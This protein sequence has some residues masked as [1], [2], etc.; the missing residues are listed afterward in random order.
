MIKRAKVVRTI[1]WILI[2]AAIV[3][4]G[5]VAF[6][7]AGSEAAK[8]EATM[9]TFVYLAILLVGILMVSRARRMRT[10]AVV[11]PKFQATGFGEDQTSN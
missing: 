10:K 9:V 7:T 2:I 5:Q 3:G 11:S 1:G 8:T 4:G 6:P